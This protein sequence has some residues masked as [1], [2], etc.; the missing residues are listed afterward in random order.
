MAVMKTPG[1]YIVEKNAFPNSVVEVA[2]A[3]PAFIGYT[4]KAEKNNKSLLNKPTRI[5]SM[6]E[7]RTYFGDAPLPK[8]EIKQVDNPEG[9]KVSV[10]NKNY[11]INRT[12]KF[13]FYYNMLLFFSNGG[14]PCYIVSVGEYSDDGIKK[15]DLLNGI[16][17]LIK[18]L[19]PTMVVIPELVNLEKASECYE[20]QQEMLNH[21]GNVMQNRFAVF[22]IFDGYKDIGEGIISNFR[23]GIGSNFLNYGAAY[24]PWINTTIVAENDVN[25][26]N[27]NDFNNFAGLLRDQLNDEIPGDDPKKIEIG[28]FIDTLSEKSEEEIPS[29]IENFLKECFK[30]VFDTVLDNPI[31]GI[32]ELEESKLKNLL[33]K[34]RDESTDEVSN[35]FTDEIIDLLCTGIKSNGSLT[36]VEQLSKEVF[37]TLEAPAFSEDDLKIFLEE[38]IKYYVIDNF[39]KYPDKDLKESLK[40]QIDSSEETLNELFS[41]VKS[42]F[43]EEV[44]KS[45]SI[46]EADILSEKVFKA[47]LKEETK[48]A[49]ILNVSIEK[50]K[51]MAHKVLFQTSTLYKESIKEM[52]RMLNRLPVSAAMAGIYTMVDN[53][54]GVWKAPANVSIAAA[55]SPTVNIC[56]EEQE[57]LNVPVN[58]KAVNAIRFFTGEGIKVWGA[59]TLDGNSLDWRYINVRRTMIML[60]ESVKNAAKAYV[61]DPNDANTWV[62]MKSMIGNFLNG[63]WKRGGLAGASPDD[64]YSVYVGLGETMTSED[65]LEGILRVTVLVAIT[66]PA[67]FIEITFQQQMQKS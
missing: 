57:D 8:F 40:T 46:E 16:K 1:V 60:E 52:T 41:A 21:C 32:S 66:R 29:D 22:D 44:L 43:S 54:K 6:A 51:A 31:K 27:I 55:E 34:T 23:E 61:F 48:S 36:D 45:D 42:K 39:E 33:K 50:E 53:T 28:K 65:I 64:A 15:A 49:S 4:E 37:K 12:D 18:E 47:M 56:H 9:N 25:Y 26:T 2:T 13:T 14:G 5:T 30:G 62:N 17:P 59:R 19:E 24:Y 58:G 3:V 10:N 67:E 35:K 11:G 63:I 38:T 20:V 7:Y